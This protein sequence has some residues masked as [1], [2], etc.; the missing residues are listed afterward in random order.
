VKIIL[1]GATGF[2]GNNIIPFLVDLG[3]EIYAVQRKPCQRQE[4]VVTGVQWVMLD[5][6]LDRPSWISASAILSVAGVGEPAAFEIDTEAALTA[7]LKITEFVSTLAF[8]LQVPRIVYLSSGGAIYGEGS[9][10]GQQSAFNENDTCCP[11]SAYGKCKLA[12]EVRIAEQ[13][14]SINLLNGLTILRASNV[15]GL[16]YAKGGRQGLVNSV[17]ERALERRPITVYGDGLVYR[18][19]LFVSD[20]ADAISKVLQVDA[21]GILNV[22]TGCSYSILDVIQCVEGAIGYC[23]ERRFE[24]ARGIDVKY[25][26]LSIRKARSVLGWNPVITLERGVDLVLKS[27]CGSLC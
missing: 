18:D 15:Y 26:S 25:S 14:D 16:H 11:I 4:S 23:L 7:E 2:I 1:L 19:Y 21:G 5:E 24:P 17:V 3:H 6:L 9:K 12:C 22:A 27:R 20:L 10:S 8:K 13:L